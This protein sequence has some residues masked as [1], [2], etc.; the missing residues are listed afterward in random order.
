MSS[1]FSEVVNLGDKHI[2][3]GGDLNCHLS[4]AIDKSPPGRQGHSL[5]A[6][7]VDA[8]CED[9]GY[10]DVWR[11]QHHTDREY[12]FFSSAAQSFT[13]I[14]YFL[15]PRSLLCSVIGYS[16]GP[17]IISDHAAVFLEYKLSHPLTRTRYWKFNPLVLTDEKF[18]SNFRDEFKFFFSTN[19]SSTSDSSLLWQTSKAFSRGIIISY[20]STKKRRQSEQIKIIESKLRRVER[21]CGERPSSQKLKEVSALRGALDTLLTM[22]AASQIRFAKQK[23]YESGNKVGR[24]LAYLTKKKTDSQTIGSVVDSQ[25]KLS[26]DT[27]KINSTFKSFY[28]NLYKSEQQPDSLKKMEDFFS[29]LNLPCLTDEQKATLEAPVSKR[30]VL[31]A[32][33]V[34]QVSRPRWT[35]R[36]I[37]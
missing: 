7:F 5:H 3:I 22:E 28:E 35:Q 26:F 25:G 12:T 14:D 10:T 2:I 36:G 24:Y 6:R 13:R 15:L 9:A 4:P 29:S 33:K 27:L 37:L 8:F 21:E 11:A 34:W 20:T 19:S 23:L 18:T 32:I 31:D 16:I 17:I 30:E 1:A